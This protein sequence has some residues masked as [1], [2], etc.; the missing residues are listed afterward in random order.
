MKRRKYRAFFS[1]F[2]A[3]L[4][5]FPA[6]V[7]AFAASHVLTLPAGLKKIPAEA[8]RGDQSIVSVLL[9]DGLSSIGSRAFADSSLREVTIPASVSSIADDAFDGTSLETV[10]AAKGTFAY[11]WMR[12]KGYITEYRALLIGEQRWL[13]FSD[14]EDPD[15][16]CALDDQTKRNVADVS[17]VKAVL[18]RAVGPQGVEGP[19]GR[20]FMT[21]PKT[22]LSYYG[23]LNAIKKTFADT[24]DQDLSVFF[25]AT[26]GASDG[27][28]DLRMAFTGD[29]SDPDQVRDYWNHRLLSFATLASWL[30][31]NVRGRVFIILESCGSGSA[32]YAEGVEENGWTLRGT[33][34]AAAAKRFTSRA[35]SAFSSADPGVTVRRTVSSETAVRDRSTGDLR[36]PK[37][38]VLAA[39]RHREKSY[40]WE[41]PQESYNFFTKWLIE[42]IGRKDSSPADTDGNNTLSLHELF[43]Y[44]K[45]YDSITYNDKIYYQHVQCY[46]ENSSSGL[47]KLVK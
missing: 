28:G 22:N 33:D 44:I 21:A 26:H 5:V 30:S 13:W 47:L 24:R 27:D 46:P 14:E 18:A 8:F 19:A 1:L 7:P 36:L 16:G 12:D 45:K 37:F 4:F 23:V 9:P 15:S 35:V 10:H 41:S 31:E 6:A 40:G 38:Y 3:L 42:G 29:I 34:N 39:S 20:A 32:V 43:S 17:N 2:L 11:Q 25:I